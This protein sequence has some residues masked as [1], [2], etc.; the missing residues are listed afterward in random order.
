MGSAAVLLL[1]DGN[2]DR[3]AFIAAPKIAKQS[4]NKYVGCGMSSELIFSPSL[5]HALC[6]LSNSRIQAFFATGR[7]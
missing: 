4:E 1:K 7:A 5:K 3:S 2:T 6:L